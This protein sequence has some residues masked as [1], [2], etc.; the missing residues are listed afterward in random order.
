[1]K[2]LRLRIR[3]L[4]VWFSCMRSS[5]ASY[6]KQRATS[7]AQYLSVCCVVRCMS[8]PCLQTGSPHVPQGPL[9]VLKQFIRL[10]AS[11]ELLVMSLLAAASAIGIPSERCGSGHV[12]RLGS[13]GATVN[14]GARCDA[15]PERTLGFS[16]FQV[17]WELRMETDRQP[18]E[19]PRFRTPE[20]HVSQR[21]SKHTAPTPP[22][23]RDMLRESRTPPLLIACCRRRELRTAS[24][25]RESA[26]LPSLPT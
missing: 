4:R 2:L 24:Q 19:N 1:M 14:T 9:S 5:A 25:R 3:L 17:C 26:R 7:A 11:P 13:L 15:V 6:S 10:Q 21:N 18:D 8:G 22:S 16:F 20:Q 23:P 12:L